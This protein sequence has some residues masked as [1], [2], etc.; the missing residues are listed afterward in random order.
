M[1][2]LDDHV[3]VI[4]GGGSGLGLGIARHDPPAIHD[5]DPDAL[6]ALPGWED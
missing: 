3:A 2:M 6:D 1:Q 5:D 4:L